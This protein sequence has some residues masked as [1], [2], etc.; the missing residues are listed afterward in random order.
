MRKM[1]TVLVILT[2]LILPVPGRDDYESW[3][4]HTSFEDFASGRIAD[5]GTN[6]YIARS[7]QLEMT[8][9]WD[10]NNDGYLDLLVIQDHNPLENTD[11]LVYWGKKGGPESIM[12]PLPG[13]QPL[14]RLLR[15]IRIRDQGVTRLPSDGGGRSLVVDLNH[16]GYPELVF[17]NFIHNYSVHMMALI[18]WGSP[19]GYQR[20][21][22]TELPT[23]LAGGVAAADFNGDGFV[24]LAF[25][26]R[27]IEGGERFGFD[28]H[29]E[30]YV[31]WNGPRG[32]REEDRTALAT[33]SAADVAAADL[34]HDGYGD[35]LFANNNSE[36]QSLVLYRGGPK[37]FQTPGET[38]KQGDAIGVT[39]AEVSGDRD[40]D[41][42]LAHKDDRV[43][44]HKG[45]GQGISRET[46]VEIPSQGAKDS[47]VG[48][49]NRDGRPDLIL[50]NGGGE[51]SY[52]YWGGEDGYSSGRRQELPTLAATDAV[53]AD[54]NGDGWVDLAFSNSHDGATR[55]VASYLYWNGPDGFH[56]AYRR[57]LQS[58]GAVSLAAGDLDQDG[59]QDLAVINQ[60][61]GSHGAIDSVVYWGNPRHHYSPA[62]ASVIPAKGGLATTA[63]LDQDG[64]VDLIFPDGSIFGGGS[65]GFRLQT[66]LEMEPANGVTVGDLNRDGYLDLTYIVGGAHRDLTPT[67]RILW[68]GEN[69]HDP[70]RRT[71]LRLGI[72]IGQAGRTADFNQDG[73]LDLVF[74]D[75]D[76]EHV[77]L[78]WGSLESGFSQ[79][80]HTVLKIQPTSNPEIA[81]LNGDGWL[82]LIFGGGWDPKRFGRP[83]RK[84]ILVWG[85]RDGFSSDRTTEI[86][87]FDSLEQAVADL[88]RDGYL[89]IV[90]TNYHAYHTRTLP[91]FIYWGGEGGS[92]SESRRTSLPAESSSALTVADMNQDS[93]LD[94]VVFNH[95][96]RG[97]HSVGSNIYWGGADGYSYTRRH[98]FQTFG[99]HF[100]R[101]RDIGNIYDRQLREE[102]VSAILEV[103]TGKSAERLRWKALTPHGTGVQFQVRSASSKAAVES[104]PW[105]GPEGPGSYF[106]ESGTA[107]R[108]PPGEAWLQYRAFLTT[109]DGGSTPVLQEVAIDVRRRSAVE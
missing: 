65:S 42:I 61:S 77:D 85:S 86:E 108:L 97:D 102:Y 78:F 92:Y 79:E 63:D 104:S 6:L 94:L 59:H 100:G 87:A 58:F 9:R 75:V 10:L 101:L 68:G 44:I 56:A 53:L 46:W 29:L 76:S 23:L 17:C 25:S 89:D 54:Y 45:T 70:S 34:N 82:D 4:T 107:L 37:G 48:D 12:P 99:P 64:W 52:I 50:A 5:G 43:T 22:R 39:L 72:R 84:A 91:A 93:W 90:M 7:G 106:R 57:E 19:N 98:W 73:A 47:R 32:F 71:D 40:P 8:Y 21:H 26:N 60:N 13:H 51:T 2:A 66:K 109:P 96:E 49:L 18:Y 95:L 14:A 33:T 74:T 67:A 41:L 1:M 88:N 20:G 62:S 80:N 15:Q 3:I 103:P 69:G 31:Y 28:L 38:W 81:D 36:H 35:L 24:D 30:S 16:D 83:T 105:R 27:G 11:V 55:D